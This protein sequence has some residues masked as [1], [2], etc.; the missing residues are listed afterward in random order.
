MIDSEKRRNEQIRSIEA[1]LKKQSETNNKIKFTTRKR[2]IRHCRP[3][4]GLVLCGACV[5]VLRN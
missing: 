2:A 4:A 5:L 1:Y 3:S